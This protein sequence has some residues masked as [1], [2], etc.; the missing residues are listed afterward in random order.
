VRA[1]GTRQTVER[2]DFEEGPRAFSFPT[3]LARTM[4]QRL[5]RLAPPPI[6]IAAP[7]SLRAGVFEGPAGHVLVHLH[8]R[9]G[10][11]RD[12]LQGTGPGAKLRCD[13][14]VRAAKLAV[15]GRPLAVREKDGRWEIDVPPIGL[16]R[17]VDVER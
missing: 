5:A 3:G 12:W 4:A 10:M 14:P 17:V 15:D 13:F 6:E 2:M 7:D 8:N 9:Q 1:D 11:R 16:Y